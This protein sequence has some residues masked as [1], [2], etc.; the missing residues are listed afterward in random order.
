M[1]AADIM[2]APVVTVHP[3]TPVTE[4]IKLMLQDQISGLPVV[5]SSGKVRGIV[6]EGDFLRR[7]ETGTQ[8]RRRRWVEWVLGPGL[9][10]EYVHAHGRT[11][12]DVMTSDVATVDLDASLP[13]IVGLM[14]KRHVKRVPV[15]R[16][17]RLLGIVTRANLLRALAVIAEDVQVSTRSIASD[18]II[19]RKILAEMQKHPWAP[20]GSVSVVVWDGDVHFWGTVTEEKQRQALRVLAEEIPG[21]RAVRDHL[22]VVPPG[23]AFPG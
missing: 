21:V 20:I 15:V 16:E 9:A 1:K 12:G 17:G 18:T 2:T 7:A 4:A 11:V 3:E 10:D 13:Q 14:E 23:L 5:D 8:R 6:S 19:R 22:E